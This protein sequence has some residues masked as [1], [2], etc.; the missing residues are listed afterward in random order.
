MVQVF[1]ATF[2]DGVF[3]PDE[4]PALSDNARVRIVVEAL[5]AEQKALA[6]ESWTALQR[7]WSASSFKSSTGPLSRDQLHERR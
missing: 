1:A 5:D 4:R 7:L 6:D 3:K 2:E